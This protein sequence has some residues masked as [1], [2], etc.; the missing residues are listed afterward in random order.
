MDFEQLIIS[1]RSIRKFICGKELKDKI[2]YKLLD[3]ARLCQS[4]KNRQPWLFMI[5]KN[6]DK[7]HIASIM[8][9]F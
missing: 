1:R 4:A 8:R 7:N 2:I 3:S 9:L 5:L 6:E